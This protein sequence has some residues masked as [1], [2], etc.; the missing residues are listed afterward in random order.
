M[1]RDEV[2]RVGYVLDCECGSD[3]VAIYVEASRMGWAKIG[4]DKCV[5]CVVR[6]GQ[7]TGHS[8][9]PD[10]DLDWADVAALC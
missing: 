7:D 1:A 8:A 4:A 9:S 2:K 10:Y 5:G 3:F 6:V